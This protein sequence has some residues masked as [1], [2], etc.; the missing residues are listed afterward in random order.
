V[1][2]RTWPCLT[3]QAEHSH[4]VRMNQTEPSLLGWQ[5]SLCRRSVLKPVLIA[6]ESKSMGRWRLHVWVPKFC[7]N[8]SLSCGDCCSWSFLGPSMAT[9]D[10]CSLCR[11]IFSFKCWVFVYAFIVLRFVFETGFLCIVMAVLISFCQPSWPWTQTQTGLS[12]QAQLT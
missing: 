1:L 3:P 4:A 2:E 5:H 12:S 7:T 8:R 6:P 10:L 11:P 9:W